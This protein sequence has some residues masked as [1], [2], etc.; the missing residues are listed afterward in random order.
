MSGAEIGGGGAATMRATISRDCSDEHAAPT[1]PMQPFQQGSRPQQQQQQQQ[2]PQQ[3][4]RQQPH[5][6]APAAAT[7]A[8]SRLPAGMVNQR[9]PTP[10][11]A[12][13]DDVAGSSPQDILAQIVLLAQLQ[14][15]PSSQ[16]PAHHPSQP[17]QVRA[18]AQA[19]AQARGQ[20]QGQ[21]QGQGMSYPPPHNN[22]SSSSNGGPTTQAA[23][24]LEELLSVLKQQKGGPDPSSAGSH[25]RPSSSAH[26]QQQQQ[27]QQPQQ[28][29][30]QQQHS[31]QLSQLQQ[32][33]AGQPSPSPPGKSELPSDHMLQALL[34][35]L[36]PAHTQQQ[37]QQQHKQHQQVQQNQWQATLQQVQ[38]HVA[39]GGGG[40]GDAALLSQVLS[41]LSQVSNG[42]CLGG[43]GRAVGSLACGGH[44][45]LACP[46]RLLLC[47]VC[48]APTDR[49]HQAVQRTKRSLPG[50]WRSFILVHHGVYWFRVRSP[51]P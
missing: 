7:A 40:G 44:R 12:G 22:N 6:H 34:R 37:Q 23:R 21:A 25:H 31:Q 8:G 1:A 51:E 27:Q 43:K 28:Q 36:L 3:Q 48:L 2:Q 33:R 10:A 41:L 19:E 47:M 42:V 11:F 20:V 24:A 13:G 29:H 39:S 15:V 9:G 17:A 35:G 49:H 5:G 4:Q 46:L 16:A 14:A 32:R 45:V 18:Q 50:G 38:H 30:S 26:W